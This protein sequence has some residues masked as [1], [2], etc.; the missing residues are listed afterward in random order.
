MIHLTTSKIREDLDEI[1]NQVTF[2]GER[3]ILQRD[4]KAIAAIVPIEDVE[5]LTEWEDDLDLEA[6][7]EALKEP[8]RVSWETIKA[9]LCLE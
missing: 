7:S 1:L 4:G 8:G 9:D 3:I 6:A 5:I 2:D